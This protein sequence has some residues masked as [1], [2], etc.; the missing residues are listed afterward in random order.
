MN[1]ALS[2]GLMLAFALIF[3]SCTA[4]LVQTLAVARTPQSE[5]VPPPDLGFERRQA[6]VPAADAKDT[7]ECKPAASTR[8]HTAPVFSPMRPQSTPKI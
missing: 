6:A 1:H 8:P 2:A 5:F 7:G 4:S 3:T